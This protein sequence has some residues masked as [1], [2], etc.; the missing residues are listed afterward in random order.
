M[1]PTPHVQESRLCEMP[2]F[3]LILY[4]IIISTITTRTRKTYLLR[5]TCLK[6]Y[7]LKNCVFVMELYDYQVFLIFF[8]NRMPLIYMVGK[9]LIW[10]ASIVEFWKLCFEEKRAGL[11]LFLHAV[12]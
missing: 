11:L 7:R 12:T 8:N 1:A 6:A 2:R 10:F 3:S 4:H 9:K 5:A